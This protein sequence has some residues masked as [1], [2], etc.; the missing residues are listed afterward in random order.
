M[1]FFK[2]KELLKFPYLQFTLIADSLQELESLGLTRTSPYIISQDVME[3]IPFENNRFLKKLSSEGSLVDFSESELLQI[4]KDY[5]P[6]KKASQ[7]NKLLAL[8]N[9]ISLAK[10]LGEDT[11][12]LD[13]EF[14]TLK[15]EYSKVIE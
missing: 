9:E 15:T 10:S 4:R 14:A 13:N 12:N 7:R 6:Q 2:V 3:S 1:K 8:N 11:T 5:E